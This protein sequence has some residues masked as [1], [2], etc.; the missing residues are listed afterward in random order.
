MSDKCFRIS[1]VN[2][3]S[4]EIKYIRQL[5]SLGHTTEQ[6][7]MYKSILILSSRQQVCF[8][9]IPFFHQ[10]KTT[11]HGNSRTKNRRRKVEDYPA[12]LKIDPADFFRL[13]E[14]SKMI[15]DPESRFDPLGSELVA[16]IVVTLE[17]KVIS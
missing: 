10:S 13:I 12:G 5:V 16:C 4:M 17:K 14:V 6:V 11:S 7:K 8:P 15:P 9:I 1:F 3:T 2:S